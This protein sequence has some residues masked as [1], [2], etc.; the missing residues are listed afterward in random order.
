MPAGQRRATPPDAAT[1]PDSPQTSPSQ[2]TH[3][4]RVKMNTAA[5]PTPF[6]QR[7]DPVLVPALHSVPSIEQRH[8]EPRAV[9]QERLHPVPVRIEQLRFRPGMQLLSP[10]ENPG[11]WRAT[12]QFYHFRRVDHPRIIALFAL[13]GDGRLAA[14]LLIDPPD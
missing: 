11:S 12:I 9:R 13:G 4:S 2:P 10:Q 5:C 7:I 8:V 3:D 1:T 14:L 6:L